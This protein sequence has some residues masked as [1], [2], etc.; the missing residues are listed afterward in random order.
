MNGYRM[1][2]VDGG[3]GGQGAGKDTRKKYRSLLCPDNVKETTRIVK[4]TSA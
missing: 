2:N 3:K 4:G 1:M